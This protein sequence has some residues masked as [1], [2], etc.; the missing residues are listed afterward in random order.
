MLV[1]ARN[2]DG[3]TSRTCRRERLSDDTGFEC[4]VCRDPWR[5]RIPGLHAY[6]H[7]KIPLRIAID[8]PCVV[9]SYAHD[10]LKTVDDDAP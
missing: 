9:R 8:V 10:L 2:I 7:V 1:E 6:L 5:D 4:S 3:T